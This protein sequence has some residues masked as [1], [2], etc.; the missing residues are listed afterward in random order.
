MQQ[1]MMNQMKESQ[2][3]DNLLKGESDKYKE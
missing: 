2:Q 3:S 1:Q